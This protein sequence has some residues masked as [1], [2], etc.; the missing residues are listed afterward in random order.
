MLEDGFNQLTAILEAIKK[1]TQQQQQPAGGGGAGPTPTEDGSS[2]APQSVGSAGFEGAGPKKVEFLDPFLVNLWT[3]VFF[4]FFLEL[5]Y[6]IC[7]AVANEIF[8]PK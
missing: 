7:R 4:G 8:F 1:S 2:S 3:L 6:F 5:I